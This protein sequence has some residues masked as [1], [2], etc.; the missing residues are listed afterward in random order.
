MGRLCQVSYPRERSAEPSGERHR[1]RRA[2]PWPC[3]SRSSGAPIPSS[4][5]WASRRPRRSRLACMR[6]RRR[7]RRHLPL[8]L[9][10]GPLRRL[11]GRASAEWRPLV[12][13][14]LLFSVQ[15]AATNV[16]TW[17]TSAAHASILVNLYAVHTVVLAHFLIPGDRLTVQEARRRPRRV[18]RASSCSAPARSRHGSPTLLGDVVV[19]IAGVLLAERTIYLARARPAAGPGEA[20]PDPGD[21]GDRGLRRRVVPASEPAPTRWATAARRLDR[22]PGRADLRI[23]LRGEPGAA[24]PLS[25]ER[26]RPRS[27]SP[28][29]SSASIAAAL[30]AG[31]PLTPDLLIACAA[32]AVGIGLTSR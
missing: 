5:R 1:P 2:R 22:L 11:S 10:H 9:G 12:V 18:F 3:S 25:A 7:R 17:L 20:P 23:Q 15:M 24:A 31:D 19:T 4:S 21:R 16:G 27:S 8:G 32:V 13:L 26:A 28:S 29:R 30:V 14:G 6:V